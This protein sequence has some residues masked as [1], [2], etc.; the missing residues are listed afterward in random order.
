MLA[1][2]EREAKQN[3]YKVHLFKHINEASNDLNGSQNLY[4]FGWI[5]A[6]KMSF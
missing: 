1:F 2:L 4:R 5:N 3:K 6:R